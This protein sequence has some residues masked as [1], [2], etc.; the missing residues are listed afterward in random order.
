MEP[1][2]ELR[3]E[4]VTDTWGESR[5]VVEVRFGGH[6][7][8]KTVVGRMV[9]LIKNSMQK[10]SPD[11]LVINLLDFTYGVADDVVGA[12][13]LSARLMHAG[14]VPC[15][16]LARGSTARGLGSLFSHGN[17]FCYFGGS[18]FESL[19]S[20]VHDGLADASRHEAD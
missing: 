15:R 16:I 2:E 9:E 4:V 12:S 7:Q 8:H 14:S 1:D 17:T 13:L 11:I 20:A 3:T 18:F 19:D 6:C 10:H 5:L